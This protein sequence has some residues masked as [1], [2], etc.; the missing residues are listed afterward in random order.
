MLRAT[1]YRPT[2]DAEA[3]RLGTV[4]LSFSD[5]FRRRIRL[6]LDDGQPFLL[7]LAEVTQLEH[8]GVLV[9]SGEGEIDIRAAVEAVV[10]VTSHD[11]AKVMRWAW[12]LGNRHLPVEFIGST[13]LRVAADRVIAE[14]LIGLGAKPVERQAPFA[15]EGGAYGGGP[16]YGHNHGH[17]HGHGH[18]HERERSRGHDAAREGEHDH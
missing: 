13:G 10:E 18:E 3:A 16:T 2:P 12:H 8:G 7:D 4:T 9:V 5:R 6:R 11:P 1:G 15:P 17:G 14:M